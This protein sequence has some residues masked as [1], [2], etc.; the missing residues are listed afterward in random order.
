LL[1]DQLGGCKQKELPSRLDKGECS[2]IG[3]QVL[4]QEGQSKSINV[5]VCGAFK[6]EVEG[7]RQKVRKVLESWLKKENCKKSD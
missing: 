1:L 3:R 2:E 6:E 5:L 4:L 7:M